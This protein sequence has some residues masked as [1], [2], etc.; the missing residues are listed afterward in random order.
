MEAFVLAGLVGVGYLYNS[1]NDN[2]DVNVN[3]EINISW[4]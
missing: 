3:R 2:V 4:E 1:K